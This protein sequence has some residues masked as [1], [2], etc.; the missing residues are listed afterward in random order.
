MRSE[1]FLIWLSFVVCFVSV[2]AAIPVVPFSFADIHQA[3]LVKRL[4]DYEVVVPRK[5]SEQGQLLSHHLTHH[6]DDASRRQRRRRRQV[7]DNDD[8]DQV[9]YRLELSGREKQ[10]HLKPNDRLLASSFIVE[11]RQGR[12]VTNHRLTPARHQQCHYMGRVKGHP[13]STV[14]V[15]TCNGLTF[16]GGH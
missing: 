14:A 12:N 7:D 1:V 11:R 16:V 6:Y 2:I 9:H 3:D 5:V 8:D 15:S 4:S 10:L 13:E